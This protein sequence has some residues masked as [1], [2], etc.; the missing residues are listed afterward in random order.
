[1]QHCQCFFDAFCFESVICHDA[2]I[3]QSCVTARRLVSGSTCACT[4]QFLMHIH[5][6]LLRLHVMNTCQKQS[7][8][9]WLDKVLSPSCCQVFSVHVRFHH[10][11]RASARWA[12]A[13]ARW[14]CAASGAWDISIT[15]I[16]ATKRGKLIEQLDAASSSIDPATNRWQLPTEA[17]SATAIPVNKGCRGGYPFGGLCFI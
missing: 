12:C 17:S 4:H 2:R 11:P 7:Y 14:A 13:S 6:R 8:Q 5:W 1:M 9:H 16:S 15:G 10:G 3:V